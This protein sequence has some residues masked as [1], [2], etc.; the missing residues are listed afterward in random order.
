MS[1]FVAREK[2]ATFVPF[3]VCWISGS[4]PTFPTRMILL[5]E[6]LIASLRVGD[7]EWAGPN[8]QTGT[9]E[10]REE[11]RGKLGAAPWRCGTAVRDCGAGLRTL[12][13]TQA[14]P[15]AVRTEAGADPPPQKDAEDAKAGRRTDPGGAGAAHGADLPDDEGPDGPERSGSSGHRLC[16]LW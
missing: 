7:M 4:C 1:R 3:C 8:G 14:L 2:W 9:G 12:V 10:L 15:G 6:R 11:D 5:T 13:E 16:F